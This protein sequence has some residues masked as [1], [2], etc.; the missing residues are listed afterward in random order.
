MNWKLYCWLAYW[1]IYWLVVI[2][3]PL[4][5][6]PLVAFHA[7]RQLVVGVLPGLA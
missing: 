6:V 4:A 7:E 5:L 3:I 1:A 2:G